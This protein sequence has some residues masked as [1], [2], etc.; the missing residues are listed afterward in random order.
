M[1]EN[2]E[3][4]YRRKNSRNEQEQ[5]NAFSGMTP[6]PYTKDNFNL[7]DAECRLA[8]R[9]KSD[10]VC[11]AIA[12]A[13]HWSMPRGKFIGWNFK[14]LPDDYVVPARIE[15]MELVGMVKR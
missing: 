7:W 13:F 12:K 9:P 5:I 14:P 6:F 10:T 8:N 4:K 2:K 3:F 11:R 1:P 15:L